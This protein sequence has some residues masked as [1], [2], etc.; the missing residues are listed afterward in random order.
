MVIWERLAVVQREDIHIVVK[1]NPVRRNGSL[2]AGDQVFADPGEV[3][4]LK[5]LNGNRALLR[6]HMVSANG[7]QIREICDD[8]D[9]AAV[10]AQVNH[11]KDLGIV[12]LFHH[13]LKSGQLF[14]GETVQALCQIVQLINVDLRAL[15]PLEHRR[16]VADLVHMAVP[17]SKVSDLK[18]FQQF[19]NMIVLFI[20]NRKRHGDLPVDRL[21]VIAHDYLHDSPPICS[22]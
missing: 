9:L 11:V 16:A 18:G 4:L 14:R 17:G 2:A 1:D 22:A 3:H 13:A 15:Q 12:H 20:G 7:G 6:Q 5:L 10:E 19:D 21:A 8:R